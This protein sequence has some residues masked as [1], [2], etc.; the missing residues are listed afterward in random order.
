MLQ[1]EE[2]QEMVVLCTVWEVRGDLSL[3]VWEDVAV[4]LWAVACL[5]QG[6]S[7]NFTARLATWL[8]SKAVTILNWLNSFHIFFLGTASMW[9][10]LSL[11]LLWPFLQASLWVLDS[12]LY[13]IIFK[14]YKKKR[15]QCKK[16]HR[17]GLTCVFLGLS[18]LLTKCLLMV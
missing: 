12:V 14:W 13:K 3:S 10:D 11:L 17:L 7:G 16:Q 9:E 15:H 4:E 6:L 8:R 18:I 1:K 5:S 2:K